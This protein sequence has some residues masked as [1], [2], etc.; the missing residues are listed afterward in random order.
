MSPQAHASIA[1]AFLAGMLAALGVAWL[2][3]LRRRAR[4]VADRAAL[5]RAEGA[6]RRQVVRALEEREALAKER[7]EVGR[8]R[9]RLRASLVRAGRAL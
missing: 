6:A 9:E 7:D 3:D 8:E 1:A 2:V 4:R 5:L